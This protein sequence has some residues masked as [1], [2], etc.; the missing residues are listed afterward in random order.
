MHPLSSHRCPVGS[1]CSLS[2][3]SGAASA[4]SVIRS[5]ALPAA[6]AACS[7]AAAATAAAHASLCDPPCSERYVIR[8]ERHHQPCHEIRD[9]NETPRSWLRGV[10]MHD[11]HE[12]IRYY[13]LSRSVKV[14]TLQGC[15]H[16]DG[17]CTWRVIPER[18]V[19]NF[20]LLL[21]QGCHHSDCAFCTGRNSLQHSCGHGITTECNQQNPALV[22][23]AISNLL[24]P[25][26]LD[27]STSRF[28]PAR[29][30]SARGS[31]QRPNLVFIARRA[32]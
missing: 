6:S 26:M 12:L 25:C 3:W 1:Q 14:D 30:C 4:H 18:A 23:E 5:S 29:G 9:A 16:K 17:T 28:R 11:Q 10:V 21:A 27:I 20:A 32:R 15:K 7:A 24:Y 8:C 31:A 2:P 19:G 22:L 13:V